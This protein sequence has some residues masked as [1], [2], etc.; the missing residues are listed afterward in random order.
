MQIIFSK[1]I[2]FAQNIFHYV[3][4]LCIFMHLCMQ[5]RVISFVCSILIYECVT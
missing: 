5:S 1:N 2:K 4:I 3:F